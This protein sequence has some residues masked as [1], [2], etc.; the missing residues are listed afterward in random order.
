MTR[1]DDTKAAQEHAVQGVARRLFGVLSAPLKRR[2]GMLFHPAG[3][4]QQEAAAGHWRS[5]GFDSYFYVPMRCPVGLLLVSFDATLCDAG[6]GHRDHWRLYFDLGEGFRE[7]DCL[8]IACSGPR[9]E[10][11]T[12]I[13][14]PAP[15]LAFRIDPCEQGGRFVLHKLALTPL[16]VSRPPSDEVPRQLA[17]LRRWGA[18]L[19]STAALARRIRRG[20][21]RRQRQSML[22]PS[23]TGSECGA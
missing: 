13:S 19:R 20:R 10:I 14:L 16:A 2:A 6:V 9:I 15:A 17:Q 22:P 23:P 1:T 3:H 5:E 12:T 11:E 21:W 7:D 8:V 4:L 18:L